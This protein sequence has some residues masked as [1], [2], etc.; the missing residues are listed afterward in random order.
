MEDLFDFVKK[1]KSTKITVVDKDKSK[2]FEFGEYGDCAN[3]DCCDSSS[4]DNSCD[5]DKSN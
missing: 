2:I 5:C 1:I 3:P 4:C